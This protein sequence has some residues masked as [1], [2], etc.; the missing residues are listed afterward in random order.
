M[1]QHLVLTVRLYDDGFGMARYHGMSQGAPEWPPAPG[2]VFQALVSGV[3][4]GNALPGHLIH[5]FEW[6]EAL[7]PPLV[8]APARTL[9]QR[10]SLF[11]PNNDADALPDPSEVSGIRTA[12]LV[13]PSLVAA[14]QPLLYAWPLA[15]D[16]S[17]AEAIV[18]ASQ[19]LYQLGRGIDMAWATARVIEDDALEALLAAYPGVVHRPQ[20]G[21]RG[22]R[23][24]ACPLPGTL[25][26][27]LHRHRAT[28]LRIEGSGKKARTLFTNP[29][30]PQ[31]ASVSYGH[32]RILVMYELRDRAL[33]R[34]WPW[35]LGLAAALV[36]RL[37]DA[38]AARLQASA[39][40]DSGQIA[41]GLIGRTADGVGAVPVAQRVRIVPLASIGSVHADHAIRR[42][43]VELPSGSALPAADVEWA[44][45][46]LDWAD[47]ET[48]EL[49]PW[50]ATKSEAD[51]MLAHYVG[52]SR[53][54][55]SVT[56]VALPE[57]ARRR[58]IEPARQRQ[59]AKGAQ[60]RL[61]EEDRALAAVRVALRHA[62]VPGHALAIRV[63][64]EPFEAKGARAEAFADGTRFAKER[65]WHVELELDRSVEGPL[66]I[67]DGRFLGLG[68]MAPLAEPWGRAA[69]E[70]PLRAPVPMP[71]AL[72]GFFA[73]DTVGS[74]VAGT[75]TPIVLARALRR[76]VMA[77]VRDT[78]GLA[79][80][81]GLDHFFS[82]HEPDGT[83]SR[84]TA[85]RHLSFQWD[86][87][88]GRLLVIAPHRLERRK[89][90]WLERRQ[91]KT[92]A[93]ALDGLVSLQAG[94]AGRFDVRA[95]PP[96]TSDPLMLS[97]RRWISLTPYA[98]TRHRKCS[99]A[100]E[101][102]AV[103]VLA[104]CMRCGL[105]RPEVRVLKVRGVSGRGLEGRVQLDFAV[106]VAG[107]VVLGRS[108]HL[109]GGLFAAADR[110]EA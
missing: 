42:F 48:G 86:Q 71:P 66:T 9:G 81:A 39:G 29:P 50:I 88:R 103:D 68:V 2:R 25:A 51:T 54:W 1:A 56:A 23:V 53:Q 10:V 8:A 78:L 106:A 69:V 27:L 52:P 105:P 47:P 24:L 100:S 92:L 4:C 43:V 90:D 89:A 12:K 20:P 73:L 108:S 3:S 72:G 101:A 35:S 15:H 65:M 62:G 75:D 85:S 97:A 38:A 80:D 84:A 49:S 93:Q 109:G 107:P 102:L 13:Q 45:S 94:V 40:G 57:S 64:R 76:A 26:S 17:R 60:E 61:S 19:G 33:P 83:S 41:R 98:A 21:V 63:Q 99:S 31:L 6:L 79:P 77:R 91:L 104:E 67:G 96:C 55:R 58:R 5:A 16:V 59:E 37:R 110:V 74:T 30:K 82:G 34:P 18:E 95:S 87:P 46:G 11:V 28:K 22:H 44:F 14:D 32:A 70:S 36:E 7:P